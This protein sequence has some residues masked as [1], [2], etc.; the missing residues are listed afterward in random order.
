M[1]SSENGV[2]RRTNSEERAIYVDSHPALGHRYRASFN[3]FVKQHVC[4]AAK[5]FLHRARSHFVIGAIKPPAFRGSTRGGV[6]RLVRHDAFLDWDGPLGMVIAVREDVVDVVPTREGSNMYDD[7]V[8]A[9]LGGRRDRLRTP[10]DRRRARATG[11]RTRRL[12]G[13]GEEGREVEFLRERE[14]VVTLFE[15]RE[16]RAEEGSF[17]RRR[18]PLE[19]DDEDG[20][21]VEPR[22]EVPLVRL[23]EDMSVASVRGSRQGVRAGGRDTCARGTR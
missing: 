1:E 22:D 7:G 9:V 17:R 4:L 8:K 11:R 16:G 15:V 12:F 10:G 20:R 2:R 14:V 5:D 23:A 6:R 3:P 18:E 19:V 21:E 13:R